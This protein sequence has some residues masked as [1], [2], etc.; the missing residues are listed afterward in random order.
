MCIRDRF[1]YVVGLL[2]EAHALLVLAGD[3]RKLG[4]GQTVGN[5][6]IQRYME[7]GVFDLPGIEVGLKTQQG[8]PLSLIH[9]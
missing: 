6:G 4:I 3:F 7:Y 1:E 5:V 8:T 2:A 9:I